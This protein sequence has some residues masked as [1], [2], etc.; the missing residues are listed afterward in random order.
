MFER[1]KNSWELAK[2]SWNVL[3]QDKALIIFPVISFIAL[4]LVSLS[5]FI[6][7]SMTGLAQ[8]IHDKN[9]AA[10]A[11]GLIVFFVFY[12]VCYTVIFY[13]NSALIG[14]SMMK[15][16]GGKPTVN[17]GFMIAN[18]NFNT[19]VGYALIAATVGMLLQWLR[20]R[21]ALGRWAAGLFGLGWNIATFLVVPVLITENIG[22]IDAVKRST[23][24]LKKTWG[25][26][27]AGNV[28][29]NVIFGLLI[30]ITVFLGISICMLLANVSMPLAIVMGVITAAAFL[31]LALLNSTL[32][33][34]YTAAVYHYAV[35]G[36]SGKFFSKNQIMDTFKTKSL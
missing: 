22:P 13:C 21:G 7:F 20:E 9:T 27:I 12:V 1:I 31:T 35:T 23:E 26:Q 30:G 3:L 11:I 8:A 17:E 4:V 15:L 14:C 34:I 28:G 18:A 10:Q 2:A 33:G 25:E 32:T 5:F 36:E 24:L 29:I 6:P 19:I 16:R